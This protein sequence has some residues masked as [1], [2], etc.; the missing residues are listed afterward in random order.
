M[1]TVGVDCTSVHNNTRF[2]YIR[3]YDDGYMWLRGE[4]TG[5][6]C[7]GVHDNTRFGLP[8][9]LGERLRDGEYV[10][11]GGMAGD[12]DVRDLHRRQHPPHHSQDKLRM[13]KHS[14]SV[15]GGNQ[16]A[17]LEGETALLPSTTNLTSI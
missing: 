10:D 9:L 7:T 12:V 1:G 16:L 13:S 17:R 5:G 11:V 2:G 8:G 14:R 3:R 4:T 15:S 6:D